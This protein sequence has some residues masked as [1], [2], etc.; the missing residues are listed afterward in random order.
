MTAN[1]RGT[2][3]ARFDGAQFCAAALPLIFFF[4]TYCIVSS[5]IFPQRC[6]KLQGEEF[7]FVIDAILNQ[8]AIRIPFQ[9]ASSSK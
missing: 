6:V 7:E 3:L 2:F 4:K 1:K 5:S 8:S 9:K